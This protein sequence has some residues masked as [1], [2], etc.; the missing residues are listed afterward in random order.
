M[1]EKQTWEPKE[2]VSA[3]KLNHMEEG[4]ANSIQK[5]S[6]E[7]IEILPEGSKVADVVAAFNKLVGNLK[8]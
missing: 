7:E 6:I 5:D 4:I 2:P 1:Y 8:K 3:K